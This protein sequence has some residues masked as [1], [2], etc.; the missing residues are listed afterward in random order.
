MT[1]GRLH[2][3][4]NS[5]APGK[6]SDERARNLYLSRYIKGHSV[7]DIADDIGVSAP[8]LSD[9]WKKLGFPI[10]RTVED[11]VIDD[12]GAPTLEPKA[13]PPAVDPGEGWQIY[14]NDRAVAAGTVTIQKDGRIRISVD[15][16]DYLNCEHVQLAYHAKKNAVGIL[17]AKEKDDGAVKLT[18]PHKRSPSY[19]V[20]AHGFVKR[21]GIEQPSAFRGKPK[22]VGGMLVLSL[23]GGAS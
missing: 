1:K 9:K 4:S 11:R 17:P 8:T 2:M 5:A 23:D 15:L 6:L 18:L 3:S 21:F 7:A 19:F 10:T 14:R 12:V 16:V 13:V 20:R 22:K